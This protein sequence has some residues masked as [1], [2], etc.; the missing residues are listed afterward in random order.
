M[1]C[2]F[3]SRL[4]NPGYVTLI[5]WFQNSIKGPWLPPATAVHVWEWQFSYIVGK[6]IN[7]FFFI[8]GMLHVLFDQE[9]CMEFQRK[10]RQAEKNP[11]SVATIPLMPSFSKSHCVASHVL[12]IPVGQQWHFRDETSTGRASA[13]RR[14]ASG[15]FSCHGNPEYIT[16]IK[17]NLNSRLWL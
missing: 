11:S 2:S 9:D 6:H 15:F 17:N 16:Y 8:T 7:S 12:K 10:I 4:K 1:S 5:L 14:G 3:S 13:A